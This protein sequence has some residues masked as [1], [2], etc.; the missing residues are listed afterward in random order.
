MSLSWKKAGFINH[1]NST[2]RFESLKAI[3][4]FLGYHCHGKNLDHQSTRQQKSINFFEGPPSSTNYA[5]AKIV[6]KA[7][8]YLILIGLL[9]N[10]GTF[11]QNMCITR[12]HGQF[13]VAKY[14]LNSA[15]VLQAV[16]WDF[17]QN[18]LFLFHCCQL[19]TLE[20]PF[21][22]DPQTLPLQTKVTFVSSKPERIGGNNQ[23]AHFGF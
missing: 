4:L 18:T 10:C 2:S 19:R 9:R 12:G 6:P 13:C 14:D 22:F 21:A 7:H 3:F 8:T 17:K 16:P 20:N 11:L 15:K 5:I 23:Q 1:L